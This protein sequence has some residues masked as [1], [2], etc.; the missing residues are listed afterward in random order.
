MVNS[1]GLHAGFTEI[2]PSVIRAY[3][4]NLNALFPLV[5]DVSDIKEHK[6]ETHVKDVVTSYTKRFSVFTRNT[7]HQGPF[8]GKDNMFFIELSEVVGVFSIRLYP[9]D[10]TYR[11]SCK[12]SR[13]CVDGKAL[14][15]LF[16]LLREYYTNLCFGYPIALINNLCHQY[17]VP[18]YQYQAD[19]YTARVTTRRFQ[20]MFDFPGDDVNYKGNKIATKGYL[21]PLAALVVSV[22]E[23]SGYSNHF[24]DSKFGGMFNFTLFDLDTYEKSSIYNKYLDRFTK[25]VSLEDSELHKALDPQEPEEAAKDPNYLVIDNTKVEIS[26]F[27]GKIIES[28]ARL[29]YKLK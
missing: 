8:Y 23:S 19:S 4:E 15:S 20:L 6:I 10:H 21:I 13:V 22:L 2:T 16:S 11:F 28:L 24:K 29:A 26:G 14:N 18:G 17:K 3:I 27:T 12:F 7:I 1:N 25:L 9:E 5:L